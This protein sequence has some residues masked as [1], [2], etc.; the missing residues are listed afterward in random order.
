M[1]VLICFGDSITAGV[2]NRKEAVLTAKM[3]DKI[4]N[5]EIINAGVSGNNTV[6]ALNRI[7][8]D[9][10]Y[11][12]PD[13]VTVLFGANDA[14]FHKMIDLSTYQNN[15]RK[16][17]QLIGTAKTILITPAPVDESVQFARTNEVLASYA[18]AVKEVAVETGAHFIDFYTE[19]LSMKDYQKK[20]KGIHNDGLHFG[21]DGYDI[22][23]ELI[24]KK[25]REI[26]KG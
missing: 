17:V 4:G 9:V 3:A 11:K 2:E 25:I 13:L 19:M 16:M 14:A 5:Y 23:V 10:I 7:K 6:D 1:S 15:I 20:L 18:N 26:Q 24:V 22:L 21:E 8:K 12:Q